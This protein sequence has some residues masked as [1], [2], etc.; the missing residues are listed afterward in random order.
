MPTKAIQSCLKQLDEYFKGKRKKFNLPLKMEG[1]PFQI[2]VWKELSKIPFGKVISYKELAQKVGKPKAFRAVGNANGKNKF[3]II[4]P[5]HR[6]IAS[7]GTLGGY[8]L[9]L[10]RKKKLLDH[11]EVPLTWPKFISKLSKLN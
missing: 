3:P 8:G 1:T 2:R 5:C 9:G 6:V 4:L 10:P 7:D 11:E